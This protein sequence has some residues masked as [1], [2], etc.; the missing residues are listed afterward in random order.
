M[1]VAV[2]LCVVVCLLAVVS[3]T[4]SLRARRTQAFPRF[5]QVF[6]HATGTRCASLHCPYDNAVCCPGK[7][8]RSPTCCPGGYKCTWSDSG[9]TTCDVIKHHLGGS[10]SVTTIRP[11][12]VLSD[13]SATAQAPQAQQ[14]SPSASADQPAVAQSAAAASSSASS[15]PKFRQNIII[16]KNI[17][18]LT[19]LQQV[20]PSSGAAKAATT[21]QSAAVSG[22]ASS[23]SEASQS[24]AS[25]SRFGQTLAAGEEGA[26]E[27][28]AQAEGTEGA[29]EAAETE[30]AD[31]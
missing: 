1:R 13:S 27:E 21:S 26:A 3:A 7:G 14:A 20:K 28:A 12:L 9:P 19:K 18:V 4:D 10:G 6:A 23:A 31:F 16:V 22:T 17:N 29:E 30:E 25:A 11:T 15:A 8:G 2:T 5:S 24:V